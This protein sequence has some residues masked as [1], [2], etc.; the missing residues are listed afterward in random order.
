MCSCRGKG[1]VNKFCCYFILP[2]AGKMI[3][4]PE[5]L[6]CSNDSLSVIMILSLNFI[7]KLSLRYTQRETYRYINTGHTAAHTQSQRNVWD[8]TKLQRQFTRTAFW[9]SSTPFYILY[10]N[11]HRIDTVYLKCFCFFWCSL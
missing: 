1:L 11:Q 9:T 6:V 7:L 5:L 2:T 3:C 10:A 8:R 4:W